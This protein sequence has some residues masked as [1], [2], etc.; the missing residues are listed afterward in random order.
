MGGPLAGSQ[1]EVG[2]G[3]P[4]AGLLLDPPGD[5]VLEHLPAEPLQPWGQGHSQKVPEGAKAKLLPERV[6]CPM[7]MVLSGLPYGEMGACHAPC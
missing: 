2:Q 5:Q 4:P 6:P 1:L 3:V 7:V